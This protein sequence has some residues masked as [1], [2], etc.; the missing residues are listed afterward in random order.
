MNQYR[1]QITFVVLALVPGMII[2]ASVANAPFAQGLKESLA[3]VLVMERSI[4][5]R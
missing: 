5:A 1:K 2:G 3:T 4:L